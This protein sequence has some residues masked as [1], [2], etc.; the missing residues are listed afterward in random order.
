MGII[1]ASPSSVQ[2]GEYVSLTVE[3]NGSLY[4]GT[5][6]YIDI[7]NTGGLGYLDTINATYMLASDPLYG[8]AN[9]NVHDFYVPSGAS[10]EIYFSLYLSDN[11]RLSST[12]VIVDDSSSGGGGSG[13][14]TEY[15]IY[16]AGQSPTSVY[17]SFNSYEVFRY[18]YTPSSNGTLTWYASGSSDTVGWIS[19]YSS[20]T[21]QSN[22]YPYDGHVEG[23]FTDD[24]SGSSFSATAS[25]SA[26]TTY[27]LYACVY[28]GNSGSATLY[29]SF[30]PSYSLSSGGTLTSSTYTY[31]GSYNIIRFT[32]TPT[33]S[34]TLIWSAST[35]VNTVGWISNSTSWN[36][37][38]YGQPYSGYYIGSYN[39]DYNGTA[40][41]ATATVTAGTTYYLYA[42]GYSGSA[43]YVT[44]TATVRPNDWSWTSTVA[45]NSQIK[46]TAAE[47]NNFTARIN[48]FRSYKGLSA[49]S[50]TTAVKN[51]TPI[52]AGI[53]NQARTA[54]DAIS[55][56]GTLPTALVSGG[57]LYASFFNGLK[58]ALNAIS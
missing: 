57:A 4:A 5:S 23:S 50:F 26:G 21:I 38:S 17:M 52:E 10:G 58:T 12:Y 13:G 32:Y 53:C 20:C 56:H 45:Q 37:D 6:Y 30:Q 46:L 41:R 34:G 22:G 43:G 33:V 19:T 54:I 40:F 36:V 14:L 1:S 7:T 8:G 48:Q 44:L 11:T 47:W 28:G 16:D 24:A 25:V 55:G 49:Y 27:Y 18:S 15:T 42:C 35:G 2:P 31:L 29:R 51:S 39:G 9:P 3:S